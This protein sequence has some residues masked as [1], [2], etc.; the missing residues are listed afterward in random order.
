[1]LLCNT[2]DL[3]E[4]LQ[5]AT[6]FSTVVHLIPRHYP[7]FI[8]LC[9]FIHIVYLIHFTVLYIMQCVELVNDKWNFSYNSSACT[10]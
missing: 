7:H 8:V 5:I 1:M 9:T 2:D 3:A 4:D 6:L 10:K